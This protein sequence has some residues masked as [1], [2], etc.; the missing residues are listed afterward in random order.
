M[1][2]FLNNDDQEKSITPESAIDALTRGIRQLAKGDALRRP[3]VDN[4]IPTENSENYFSLSSM[5]GGIR[6]PGYF[7]VRLKPDIYGWVEQFGRMRETTYN[8]RPGLYGGLVLLF[9]T[10]NA[11]LLAI[12]NDGYVQ[13]LRVAATAALGM[14]YL[15]REDSHVMGIYGSGGMAKFFPLTAKVARRIERIQVYSPNRARLEAYLELMKPKMNCEMVLADNLEKVAQGADILASCTTSMEPVPQADWIRPGMHLNSVTPWEFSPDV[16]AKIDAAGILVRRT[17]PSAKG[18]I[19]DGFGIKLH[20]MSWIAGTEA[21]RAKV[22]VGPRSENR[23]VNARIVD[24]CDWSTDRPYSEQRRR[25]E[26]T[27]LA[28]HSYGTLEGD[29]G[30][31]AGIQGVQ[32]A[33]IAGRIYEGAVGKGLGYKFPE[34]MFVQD[35]PT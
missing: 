2:I 6:D 20:V 33:S 19:D 32:F 31:S 27:V 8:T 17:P 11:A 3:R 14:K 34:G 22:P 9:S 7:A 23:Y 10:R 5:E 30:I 29:I 21:E 16:C 25:D 28:N 15:S 18:L 12:M 35:I 13:H 24:C 1:A 4:L 26:I